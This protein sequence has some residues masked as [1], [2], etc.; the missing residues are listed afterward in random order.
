M[1]PMIGMVFMVPW[2]WAPQNYQLCQGQLV[3]VQQY[4]ALYSLMGF[5]F[6]GN[7]SSN[8]NLPNLQGRAPI[9]TG[10]L[11]ATQYT[12]GNVGG[13]AATTLSQI[14][15]PAHIHGSSFVPVGGS[16]GTPASATGPVTLPFSVTPTLTA[17]TSG[18][19]NIANAT[20]TGITS[21]ASN[22]VLGKAGGGAGAIY[23]PAGTAANVPI[24]PDQTFTGTAS[25][26]VSGNASGN[27]TLS[28]TGG[29][30]G[31]TGG[32]V[33]IAPAGSSAPFSNMQPYLA[34]SFVIAVNGIYPDR[35]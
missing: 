4:E 24:G 16:A 2:S 35:P 3:T 28:V 7:G 34:M 17:T 15:L 13:S 1:D 25:G 10:I 27:V 32:S 29:G 26:T 11:N 12:L 6:G 33:S 30:G 22:A 5:T 31:I 9:G 23:A 8:F 14:Q 20:T 18:S 19:L 21:P